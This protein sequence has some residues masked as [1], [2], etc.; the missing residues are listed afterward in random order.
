MLPLVQRSGLEALGTAL[1]AFT[2]S[3]VGTADLNGFEQ[4]MGIG[5]C[6]A[7]PCSSM[8]LGVS[9]VPISTLQ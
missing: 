6:L 7:L 1:L 3:R 4:S 8:S 5:L 2:I 9:A